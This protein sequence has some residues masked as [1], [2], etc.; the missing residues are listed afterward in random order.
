[1]SDDGYA[2]LRAAIGEPLGYERAVEWMRHWYHVDGQEAPG[3]GLCSLRAMCHHVSNVLEGVPD[4]D[5]SGVILTN[6]LSK[7]WGSYL[8]YATLSQP[9]SPIPE[10]MAGRDGRRQ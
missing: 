8:Y 2:A 3:L 7:P 9:G 4:D 10:P 6:Y 1:M 5:D